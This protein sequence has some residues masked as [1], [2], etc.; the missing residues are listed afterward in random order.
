MLSGVVAALA[1]SASLSADDTKI[2]AQKLI[3]KWQPKDKGDGHLVAIE[4]KSGG[5]ATVTAAV[6]GKETTTE[7]TYK[8]DGKKLTV[9]VKTDGEEKAHTHTISKLTDTELVGADEKGKEHT[10]LRVKDK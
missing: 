6:D 7:G 1:L 4:F 3:G 10:L 2:D 5:K 9:T 8:L